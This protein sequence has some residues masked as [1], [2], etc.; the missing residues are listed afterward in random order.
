MEDKS[1][2]FQVKSEKDVRE[3]LQILEEFKK[4]DP[5]N[6]FV[7]RKYKVRDGV[8]LRVREGYVGNLKTGESTGANQWQFID[9]WEDG[10]ENNTLQLLETSIIK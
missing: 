3:V 10:W 1:L 6:P 4:L 8:E 7:L 9:R 2:N 5:N